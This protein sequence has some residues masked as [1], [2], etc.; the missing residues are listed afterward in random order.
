MI[1]TSHHYHLGSVVVIG[2][3]L[4]RYQKDDET[5]DSGFHELKITFQLG[6]PSLRLSS[7]LNP[8]I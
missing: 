1:Y 2:F 7:F 5:V 3:S 6:I 4:T 8:G